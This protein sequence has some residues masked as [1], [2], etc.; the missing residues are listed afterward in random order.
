MAFFDVSVAHLASI[1]G[2]PSDFFPIFLLILQKHS[3]ILQVFP[4]LGDDV[5]GVIDFAANV[6]GLYRV[7]DIA[8]R[9]FLCF[10]VLDRH[11]GLFVVLINRQQV[12]SAL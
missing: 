4:D 10:F 1:I 12:D 7:S 5:R 2:Q 9:I 11:F 6:E 3:L 8:N